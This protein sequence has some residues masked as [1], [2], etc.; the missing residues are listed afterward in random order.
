MVETKADHRIL[1]S[2][3]ND[4]DSFRSRNYIRNWP[5]QPFSQD[6]GLA[7]SSWWKL[8]EITENS[9]EFLGAANQVA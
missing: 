3:D 4:Q 7:S 8:K 5:L 9:S 1:C 6:F 2:Y